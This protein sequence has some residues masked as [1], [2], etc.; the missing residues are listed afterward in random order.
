MPL[1]EARSLTKR[2][3]GV[4]A[5]NQVAFDLRAGE[6]HALCGEN[7]AGKSTLIKTLSGIHPFGSYEGQ[8]LMD[9]RELRLR[10]V[11]DAE[12]AGIGVIYQELAL[13]GD[14]T[15]AENLFLGREPTRGG[16]IDWLAVYGQAKELIQRFGIDLEPAARV[17]DLGVGRQQLVEI[18]RALAK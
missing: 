14:M 6:I 10:G 13:V 3:P 8:I 1:L 4:V 11:A 16:L 12:S 5:L 7:G 9:G 18:V 17:R 2:F 15:V